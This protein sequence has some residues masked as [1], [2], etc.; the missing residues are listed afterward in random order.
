[1][2]PPDHLSHLNGEAPL[3]T[4][5]W[6]RLQALRRREIGIRPVKIGP[7]RVFVDSVDR[8]LAALAWKLGLSHRRVRRLIARTIAPGMVAVDVGANV[9][10]YSVTLARRVGAAGRVYALEPEPGNVDLLTRAVGPAR[11][12]QVVTRQVAAADYSGW[13]TLYLSPVDRGDHRIFPAA[14]ERRMV[15]VR[16]VSL[17]D[18]LAE[19]RR[20]DFIKLSV[21]G[22]EV[23]A[24][25]GLGRTLAR[26]P[27]LRLLC[28]ITPPL[29]A[30]A[31]VGAAALFEP[32]RAAG[33]APHRLLDDGSTQ[34]VSED[35]LWSAAQ[36][37]GS[38]LALFVR[39][40]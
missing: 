6:A 32:L 12:P 34:P 5:L 22:A 29:L 16:S 4:W 23:S 13:M 1:V 21:Q 36:A 14:E 25:R 3:S 35:A 10:C 17:D 20:V 11:F 30:R 28:A 19:E 24:L 38:V 40:A 37:R 2:P 8:Y 15:T 33:L 18:V 39:E 31:G 9:G 26:N 7:D 27:E